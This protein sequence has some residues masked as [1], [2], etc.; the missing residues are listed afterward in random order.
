MNTEQRITSHYDFLDA[1]ALSRDIPKAQQVYEILRRAIIDLNLRPGAAVKK[2]EIGE[3]L[4]VS[5]TPVSEAIAK[6]EENGL[7]EV[8][9]QHGTFVSKIRAS[10]VHQGAFLRRAL[11][12]GA[13]REIAVRASDD[14]IRQLQKNIR[15][16]ESALQAGDLEDFHQR[17]EELHR[18]ICEFTGYPRLPRLLDG[19]R[20][21]LDRVRRLFLPD[22]GRPQES[23]GEHKRIVSA[24]ADHDPDSAAEA[25]KTHLDVTPNKLEQLIQQRPELF[26]S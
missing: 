7:V 19:S 6:L 22:P 3:K 5:K 20:G 26:E 16:Q 9:P 17:D 2:E 15:Y 14:Q 18:L 11:E 13:V 12:V 23:V 21:Q 10:D 8:F 24:I 4:R 1:K 25:I